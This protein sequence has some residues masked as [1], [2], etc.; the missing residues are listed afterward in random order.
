[1][2]KRLRVA[3]LSYD[4]GEYCVRLASALATSADV[5]LLLPSQLAE[6]YLDKLGAAVD[7]RPFLKPRLR[8]PVA[9]VRN[10]WKLMHSIHAYRPDVIHIQDGHLWFNLALPALRHDR[11]VLTIH[12][13]QHHVGDRDSLRR[14]QWMLDRAYRRADHVIVHAPQLKDL[15][16]ARLGLAPERVHVIPHV[17]LGD[18]VPLSSAPVVGRKVL[19]FGRI[20]PYKGLDYLIRAEPL[21]STAVPDVEI[22][23]AGEGEDFAR[24]RQM[25]VHPERFTVLNT[26]ISDAQRSE[27]FS[28]A[29][30]VV[31]PYVDASQSGVIPLAYS[32]ARPVVATTVGGL[33]AMVDDGVTGYLVPPCD[34][35]ALATAIV[36]TLQDPE[37]RQRLGL[38]GQRKIET[39]CSAPVIA[40]QLLAVYDQ[41]IREGSVR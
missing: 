24:Y 9:Q 26:Y 39:E 15:V 36:R 23:I 13:P 5:R 12:D 11:M 38:N 3:F 27:L 4:Y 35:Q 41:A 6:P 28:Q 2:S 16:V 20:W 40:G 14:P 32:H 19:F 1:M 34:E 25:M 22:V 33:P 37:L 30:V 17:E 29:S 21:I 7:Y 18:P 8:Q 31:L 10:T